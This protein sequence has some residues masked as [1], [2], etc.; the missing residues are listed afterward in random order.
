[1]AKR[2][3]EKCEDGIKEIN[4]DNSGNENL[5]RKMRRFFAA[6][7][8]KRII[9]VVLC[10][11]V[12]VSVTL[13]TTQISFVVLFSG[14]TIGI[15]G[16]RAE[17]EEIIKEIETK[18]SEI[19]GSEYS[20]DGKISVKAS[21]GDAYATSDRLGREI[22][23]RIDEICEAFAV[24]IDGSAVAGAVSRDDIQD[25]LNIVLK[26][27]SSEGMEAGF[28]QDV[29][30]EF[31]FISCEI[32]CGKDEL[33]KLLNPMNRESDCR[34]VVEAEGSV[35]YTQLIPYAT[36]YY[37]DDSIYEGDFVTTVQGE[38]G[39]ILITEKVSYRNGLET[40]RSEKVTEMTRAPVSE[41]IARGTMERPLTASYGEYIWPAQGSL[42]S[43]FGFRTISIGSSN[44]SGIDIA[45]GYG[46]KVHAAD[47][48]LVVFT[49]WSSG[50]GN[51]V[52][53]EHDNGEVTY[54]AHCNEFLV[55]VGERVYQGQEIAMMGETGLATGVHVHF[56]IRVDG[57]AIDPLSR[58][59]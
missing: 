50:Y 53:I 32:M 1:M 35:A 47:G 19:T 51:L 5:R 3:A 43:Y 6:L 17:A 20:L 18:V 28:A 12:F 15:V 13:V 31:G 29:S 48:G 9:M 34:L 58:L 22:L 59:P 26:R 38:N 10:L 23:T 55:S 27:F 41:R 46:T 30:V 57:T 11:G 49:D 40:G 4:I 36:E 42:T 8:I 52:K 54:Y 16:S 39:E 21:Y 24:V 2:Y 45:N 14:E 37:D 56:E 25:V 33:L 7:G 44:H